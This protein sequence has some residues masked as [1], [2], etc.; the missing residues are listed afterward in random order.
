MTV[1]LTTGDILTMGYTHSSSSSSSSKAAGRV[2]DMQGAFLMPVSNSSKTGA[3][4]LMLVL[5]V[6]VLQ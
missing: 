1:D 2:V 3:S 4:R 6:A 5:V